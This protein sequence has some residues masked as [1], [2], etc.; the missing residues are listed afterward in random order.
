MY[1]PFYNFA[2]G[3]YT[4]EI[5]TDDLDAAMLLPQYEDFQLIYTDLR[6]N[7]GVILNSLYT[8][9]GDCIR[10]GCQVALCEYQRSVIEQ[11]YVDYPFMDQ[12]DVP[13][14]KSVV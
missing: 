3:E 14:R 7:R 4:N 13:D 12:G 6:W 5:P 2:T 9:L 10:Q 1:Q 8:A 11:V